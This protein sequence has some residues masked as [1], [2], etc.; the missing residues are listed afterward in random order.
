MGSILLKIPDLADH[1]L[2]YDEH[3][4]RRILIFFWPGRDA[5]LAG[6]EVGNDARRLAQAALLIRHWFAEPDFL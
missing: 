6:L 3:E 2:I 4:T 5:E 1:E